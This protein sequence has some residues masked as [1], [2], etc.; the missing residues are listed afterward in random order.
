MLTFIIPVRHPHNAK[1]WNRLKT[2]LSQTVLSISS[3][4][5]DEWKAVVVANEGADLPSLPA[6]F[7]VRWVDF[8]P[9]DLYEQGSADKDRFY[10]AFRLDKGRRVLAGMQHAG[11]A[12]HMMIVDADDFVSNQLA[13]FVASHPRDAGWYL[14]DGYM[15]TDGGSLLYVC[16]DFHKLCGTSH[17]IRADL[18]G[19]PHQLKDVPE[20][21]IRKLLGSHIFVDTH[22][23]SNGTPLSQLPFL[24]AVYRVGHLS[25]HSKSK[26]II[27][28]LFLDKH[29]M[30]HPF[31][32]LKRTLRLRF[33]NES[34]QEEFSLRS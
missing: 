24:G 11:R 10:D 21:Y 20:S 30:A 19:L 15:W 17:I 7:D 6:G 1:D 22:L 5:C 25:A 28:Q 27:S 29:V 14:A 32:I 13:A 23:Q 2:E 16:P 33:L 12:G 34:L 4:N 9:N 8:P 26:G 31:G 18:Y 3:Q